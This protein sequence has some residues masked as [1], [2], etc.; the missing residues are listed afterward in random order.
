M[1]LG[2]E[3]IRCEPFA[4]VVNQSLHKSICDFCLSDNKDKQL[5]KCT[6]C[7][8]VY[9]CDKNCQRRSWTLHREECKY[10]SAVSPKVPTDTVRL[11]ARI[12]LKLR[13]GKSRAEL[14]NKFTRPITVT[15]DSDHK[16]WPS[17]HPHSETN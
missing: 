1:K 8:Y 11:I 4:Y 2:E 3:F 13:M 6:S 5:K 17:V 14:I 16:Y 15:V 12:I 9:Y 10:L 7:R